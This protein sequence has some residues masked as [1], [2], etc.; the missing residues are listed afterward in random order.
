MLLVILPLE[1][2]LILDFTI[3]IQAIQK[4][5]LFHQVAIDFQKILDV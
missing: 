1:V 3:E 4:I 5:S 2:I